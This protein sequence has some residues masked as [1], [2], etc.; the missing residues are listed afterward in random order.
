MFGNVGNLVQ[1]DDEVGS[2]QCQASDSTPADRCFE[3]SIR[4]SACRVV[5]AGK[6]RVTMQLAIAIVGTRSWSRAWYGAELAKVKDVG[7]YEIIVRNGLRLW[8]GTS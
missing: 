8:I 5:L 4:G 1:Y 7:K 6:Y 3:G 2:G